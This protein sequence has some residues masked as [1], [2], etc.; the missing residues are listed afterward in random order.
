MIRDNNIKNKKIFEENKEINDKKI[1]EEDKNKEN[2]KE[3]SKKRKSKREVSILNEQ[4]INKETLIPPECNIFPYIPKK[5]SNK[6]KTLVLDL[7]ET[8]V[9]SYFQKDPPY[10]PDVSFDIDINEQTV[11]VATLVRPGARYFLEKMSKLYEIVIFTASLSQYAVPLLNIIDKKKYCEHKLFREHCFSY[12]YKGNLGYVKDLTKLNRDINSLIILDNNPNCYFFNKENGIPIKTWLSDK[13]DRE[14]F[15]VQPYL[16]FLSNDFITD[17]RPIL[18]EI[19]EGRIIKYNLFDEI[20]EKYNN[21]NQNNN[22]ENNGE[23]IKEENKEN[24]NNENIEKII[25]KNVS[26]ESIKNEIN[27]SNNDILNENKNNNLNVNKKK[28][29]KEENIIK[30]EKE[31]EKK[32]NIIKNEKKLEKEE[33]IIKNGKKLEEDD[34]I[35]KN[36][37]KLEEDDNIIKN[38]K[39][40]EIEKTIFNNE[41]KL[42]IDENKIKSENSLSKRRIVG[43][44][45][46]QDKENIAKPKQQELILPKEHNQ[47]NISKEKSENKSDIDKTKI[48]IDS[49][50]KKDNNKNNVKS[51][52]ENNNKK[53]DKFNRST[54]KEDTKTIDYNNKTLEVFKKE[55]NNKNNDSIETNC[56][57]KKKDL[58]INK[59]IYLKISKNK[60]LINNIKCIKFQKYA[61]T[62]GNDNL[63]NNRYKYMKKKNNNNDFKTYNN[64][65]FGDYNSNKKEKVIINL[66]IQNEEKKEVSND[67]KKNSIVPIKVLNE[68]KEKFLKK[69]INDY[70]LLL[71]KFNLNL[72]FKKKNQN[73]NILFNKIINNANSRLKKYS[74]NKKN[75]N[76]KE[77]I[78]TKENNYKRKLRINKYKYHSHY[79]IGICLS[80]YNLDDKNNSFS[81]KSKKDSLK[82]NVDKN[83]NKGKKGIYISN[84]NKDKNIENIFNFIKS[85]TMCNL[86][87]KEDINIKRFYGENENIIKGIKKNNSLFIHKKDSINSYTKSESNKSESNKIYANNKYIDKP[88][89]KTLIIGNKVSELDNIIFS[90]RIKANIKGRKTLDKYNTQKNKKIIKN[91]NIDIKKN[92]KLKLPLTK[93]MNLISKLDNEFYSKEKIISFMNRI[94]KKITNNIT[95]HKE[96]NKNNVINI[97]GLEQIK[98]LNFFN[99]KKRQGLSLGNVSKPPLI[100]IR[101]SYS[102]IE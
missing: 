78:N 20:I 11:H 30:N 29:E 68:E 4:A 13:N 84:K 53:D 96:Q 101:P 100:K 2:K 73:K 83:D 42:E 63:F 15:I 98:R 3:N 9:H 6:K 37:K 94:N 24:C 76:T 82:T 39:K 22:N 80:D 61:Q 18:S 38:E 31:L 34:N 72:N 67:S 91:F 95:T 87:N 35:I 74:E 86:S 28:L 79:N 51:N 77:V 23:I 48:E 99:E 8:L 57:N 12:N 33:N 27:K 50:N 41:K 40:L 14:L 58:I 64:R 65:V 5:I 81:M 19:K 66:K 45:K 54:Q 69:Q 21:I 46:K 44:K 36:E 70:E 1:M 59:K 49:D 71:N 43:N 47:N 89:R 85:K 10:E 17:V 97:K 7:D 26:K 32:D 75:I 60:K 92:L 90:K 93:R 88:E 55:E 52:R 102:S 25:I 16:E 62:I 56:K